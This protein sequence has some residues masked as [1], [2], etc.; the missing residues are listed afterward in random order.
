MYTLIILQFEDIPD[1]PALVRKGW[2]VNEIIKTRKDQH[3]IEFRKWLKTI[4]NETD[5]EL[6]KAYYNTFKRNKSDTLLTK[7][8]RFGIINLIG[9]P[10]PEIS[11][12]VSII[13]T[14]WLDKIRNGWNPRI[15]IEKHFK[16][17]LKE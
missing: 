9:I 6:L 2:T 4:P 17:T 5:N 12:P 16:Y 8:I 7:V 14:F 11:L 15:F 1:I 13:D 3:C 10:A